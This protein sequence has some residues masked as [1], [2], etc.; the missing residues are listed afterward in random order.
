MPL[1]Y[2]GE[3]YSYESWFHFAPH[4]FGADFLAERME[5]GSDVCVRYL[6]IVDWTRIIN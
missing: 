5:K 2:T 3:I 6:A 4:N 1:T